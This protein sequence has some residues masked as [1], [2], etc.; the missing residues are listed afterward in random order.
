M[1]MNNNSFINYSKLID[2]AMQIVIYK[3]LSMIG[4][5]GLKGDHHFFISFLTRAKDVEISERLLSKYPK[6]MTIVLQYQFENLIVEEDK[7]S[8]MLSFSGVKEKITIPYKAL[9]AF[10][11][12]SVKFGIQFKQYDNEELILTSQPKQEHIKPS[13]KDSNVVTMDHFRKKKM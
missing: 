6:E 2:E 3:A 13:R 5:E 7:F 10:A 4:H 1:V 12:P 8:V 11:D 9:T